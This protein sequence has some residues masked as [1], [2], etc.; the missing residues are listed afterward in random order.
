MASKCHDCGFSFDSGDVDREPCPK[1]GSSRRDVTLEMPTIM[2]AVGTISA[3]A[4]VKAVSQSS[5]LLHTLIIPAARVPEGKLIEAVALP[6]FE[7]L[8]ELS[9]DPNFAFEI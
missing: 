8:G 9:R 1:C 5:L 7:I 3:T 6:W 2:S 4:T